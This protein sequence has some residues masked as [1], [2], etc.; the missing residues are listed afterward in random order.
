MRRTSSDAAFL[1]T[2]SV[3]FRLRITSCVEFSSPATSAFLMLSWIGASAVAMK[4]V[5]R[6]TPSAPEKQ[7]SPHS[8]EEEIR[9][10]G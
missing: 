5:P 1:Y 7:S 9:P 10:D 8:G 2:R 3:F 6:L 4:R